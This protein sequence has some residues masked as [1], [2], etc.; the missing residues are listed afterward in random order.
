[1]RAPLGRA[2][3]GFGASAEVLP[4]SLAG[5]LQG[6]LPFLCRMLLSWDELGH[7]R[8]GCPAGLWEHSGHICERCT[9][10]ICVSRPP[11]SL[12]LSPRLPLFPLLSVVIFLCVCSS[13]S[14]LVVPSF[15]FSHLTPRFIMFLNFPVPIPLSDRP[16]GHAFFFL[17][18]LLAG[19]LRAFSGVAEPLDCTQ[20]SVKMY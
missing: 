12:L 10:S 14:S 6:H 19:S 3:A 4:P 1:M 20:D 5:R 13:T 7:V 11:S 15:S 16:S 17:L 9:G 8:G 18:G 2:G